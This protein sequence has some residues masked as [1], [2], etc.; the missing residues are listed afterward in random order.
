[1]LC[2][3]VLFISVWIVSFPDTG[4]TLQ[5]SVTNLSS[6]TAIQNEAAGW[7]SSV[8]YRAADGTIVYEADAAGNRIPDFSHAGYRGGGVP[9][10]QVPVRMT[11]SP[12]ATGDDT[13]QIQ[14]ALDDVGA[15]PLDENGLRGAVFL[16]PGSYRISGRLRIQQ[17]GVVL[18]GSGDGT[19]PA[20]NTII[21]AAKG[22]GDVSIQIGRGTVNW[23]IGSGSPLTEISTEFVPNGNRHFEVLD[24][25]GFQVG[26]EI[27]IFHP[28]SQAWI[29]AVDYGGR[30]LT[31]P[32][33]WVANDAGLNIVYI[34]RITGISG[35]V[36]AIDVPVFNHLERSISRSLVFK[37]GFS[38]RISESG[39]EDLR[40]ILESDGILANNHGNNAIVFNGVVDSWAKGVTVL[41]FR[42]QGIGV[43]NSTHVTVQNA[44]ALEPHSP[45]E[46]GYRYN[47]N[48]QARANN[49]L[50]TDVHATHGR[51]CFVSNGTTS[52]SGVVFHR[53]TS[54]EAYNSTEGHRR[55][56]Q[57]LLF[58]NLKFTNS[59]TTTLIGLYNRG[60]YGTRHGWSAAHSVVWNSDVGAGKVIVIQQP[61]TAQNYGIANKGT[62]RGTGPFPGPVGFIEGTG[63][64]PEFESLY[65]AQL[66]DRITYG[67]PPD[68]PA[69]LDLAYDSEISSIR[70]DWSHLSLNEM[71]LVLQRSTNNGDFEEV[72]RFRSSQKSF[73]DEDVSF[74]NY[75]YRIAAMD[76]GR[77]SAWSNIASVNLRLSPFLLRNPVSGASVELTGDSGRLFNSW[78]DVTSND[79]DITYTWELDRIDGDFSAPVFSRSVTVNLVQIPYGVL[80]QALHIAGVDSGDTF[81][82]KWAVMASGGPATVW[83][84]TENPIQIKR[85][86]VVTSI[87]QDFTDIPAELTL[88]QN[89]P[90]PFNPE[91]TISFAL[92]ETGHVE[93]VVYDM[94][95]RQV[96]RLISRVMT[97]GRH[98]VRWD[99]TRYA[100]GNYIFRLQTGSQSLSRVMTLLK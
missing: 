89:Y 5:T 77:M 53:G 68:M 91:S 74:E 9:L 87:D 19:D 27:A 56:S 35:N 60:D 78:W 84:A 61:P 41:H 69:R 85:G 47:F 16:N 8:I 100:S 46:G 97:S 62:V 7:Q 26:D 48:V 22:I 95:G 23:N 1:M 93:L 12:S 28:S 59:N 66:F 50:F 14:A 81:N 79:F 13:N 2:L 25:N 11:L 4:W 72:A 17:S 37:P 36:I 65:E 98:E 88:Q 20:Q 32:S 80:D 33:P 92:P 34:R 24:A 70:L 96:E 52:A 3:R 43:T 83:S 44:R 18:R 64:T 55:W 73:I 57:A 99:A 90:N 10:P 86:A 82:G 45:I 38:G 29:E 54:Q 42:F 63:Q 76:N 94:M 40:L 71:D 75:S 39:V 15:M 31:S 67:V 58:D 21:N 51:H 6:G 49:V 30:P